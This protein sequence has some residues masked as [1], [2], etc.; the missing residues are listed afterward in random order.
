MDVINQLHTKKH[1][2]FVTS[3]LFGKQVRG[4]TKSGTTWNS[5]DMK[6]KLPFKKMIQ[7]IQS[8][9]DRHRSLGKSPLLRRLRSLAWSQR[10]LICFFTDDATKTLV[11]LEK[12]LP[13]LL[14]KNITCLFRFIPTLSF[15][16]FLIPNVLP[17]IPGTMFWILSTIGQLCPR[18]L[19]FK[20]FNIYN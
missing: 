19:Q 16:K 20:N 13:I 5:H 10:S 14:V 4:P 12:C 3:I 15:K 8:W 18:N 9:N 2:L 1:I 6:Q 7:K 17:K 11:H